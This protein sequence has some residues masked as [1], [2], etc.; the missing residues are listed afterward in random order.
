MNASFAI[1]YLLLVGA[2]AMFTVRLFRG[3][4]VVDRI[5]ALDGV[6]VSILGAVL[7]EASRTES[8]FSIDTV[9]VV[10]LLSFVATGV[11]ARYVEQKGSP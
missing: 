11:L 1:A 7:I 9:L 5:I 2:A 6:L 4:D 8:A 3:P 10:A